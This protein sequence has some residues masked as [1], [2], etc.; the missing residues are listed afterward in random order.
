M[1]DCQVY[2][3][4][5][6]TS[7]KRSNCIHSCEKKSTNVESRFSGELAASCSTA[8]DQLQ[9]SGE[10][11]GCK[12]LTNSES[13]RPHHL[14]PLTAFPMH[15]FKAGKNHGWIRFDLTS[16]MQ[17]S[18]VVP[19]YCVHNKMFWQPAHDI[20][21]NQSRESG[22]NLAFVSQVIAGFWRGALYIHYRIVT[23][24]GLNRKCYFLLS[25]LAPFRLKC[26]M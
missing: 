26:M 8:D 3:K 20:C 4:G 24:V 5:R 6:F 2:A 16:I 15:E 10:G 11:E 14:S 19:L 22:T 18:V 9:T 21:S 7:T 12:I 23:R 17:I 13:E 1:I 25:V